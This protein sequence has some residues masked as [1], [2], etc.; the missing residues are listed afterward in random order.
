MAMSASRGWREQNNA[1]IGNTIQGFTSNDIRCVSGNGNVVVGN[2]C[3]SAVTTNIRDA[4]VSIA[5]VG[6]GTGFPV[7]T[8]SASDTTPTIRSN[9]ILARLCKSGGAV[10]ITHFDDGQVG[11]VVTLLAAHAVTITH[12]E[13]IHLRRSNSF[14][15]KAG[16]VL[17]LAMFD[18][19]VWEE[20][21]RKV[22]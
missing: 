3:L 13:N 17:E 4:D 5:N 12:G 16:D 1:I 11:D 14:E 21:S 22:S 20:I 10:T 15:M 6:T 2:T 9:G 7:L 8:F 18:D 19:Q